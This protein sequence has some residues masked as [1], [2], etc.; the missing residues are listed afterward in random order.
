M[1]VQIIRAL[2]NSLATTPPRPSHQKKL[3]GKGSQS[4]GRPSAQSP[5]QARQ[6][7]TLW[8]PPTTRPGPPL[9]QTRRTFIAYHGTPAATNA[10]SILR[11]GWMVGSG[12]AHGDGIYLS[13][14]I[15][16]AIAYAGS[17]GLYLKCRVSGKACSWTP[18]MQSEF[19][20]WCKCRMARADASAKTSFLIQRGVE[21]VEVGDVL[22]VLA[23]QFANPTAW[24]WKNRQIKIIGVYRVSDDR[25]VRL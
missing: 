19:D 15:Q 11:H 22:V 1:L 7:P 23:P 17:G 21:L 3:I 9:K 6:S 14:R 25:P 13:T 10:R 5:Q 16:T 18:G 24:K 2:A 4:P 12:N 8:T 20:R